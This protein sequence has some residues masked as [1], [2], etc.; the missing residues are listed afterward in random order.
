MSQRNGDRARADLKRKAK[1]RQRIGIR[2][3]REVTKQLEAKSVEAQRQ[4]APL[5]ALP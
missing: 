4:P 1:L 2:E 3:L 5:P